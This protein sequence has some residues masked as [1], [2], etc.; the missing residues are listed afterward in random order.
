MLLNA[1]LDALDKMPALAHCLDELALAAI[2]PV[3]DSRIDMVCESC[4]AAMGALADA[5]SLATATPGD[6]A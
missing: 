4:D 2:S 3:D 6:Y 1:A 5:V